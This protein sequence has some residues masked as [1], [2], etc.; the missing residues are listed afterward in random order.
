MSNMV[1]RCPKCATSFRITSGQLKSANGAVR[2]G[3]CLHIFQAQDYFVSSAAPVAIEKYSAVV[4]P[5]VGTLEAARPPR[6]P[7]VKSAPKAHATLQNTNPAQDKNLSSP[8]VEKH[9]Q[10][11]SETSPQQQPRLVAEAQKP[12]VISPSQ[13]GM[14]GIDDDFLI[15][16]DME[17]IDDIGQDTEESTSTRRAPQTVS[18]FERPIHT[19]DEDE[20]QLDPDESWAMHL[21]DE[22]ESEMD[23]QSSRVSDIDQIDLAADNDGESDEEMLL[24]SSQPTDDQQDAPEQTAENPSEAAE[25]PLY[26]VREPLFSLVDESS[27]T[28]EDPAET[29]DSLPEKTSK[30][31]NDSRLRAYD[32]SRAALLMNISPEPLVMTSQHKRR[33]H[34]KPLWFLLGGLMVIA[35][36]VQ[37]G[38]L[39]FSTLSRLEPYR[40]AYAVVCPWLGCK[41]PDLVDRQKIRTYNLVVR[42]HPHAKD[43]LIVDAIILNTA[44]FGQPFP[45]LAL[46]F[47]T[48]DDQL[49]ATRR[50]APNEY[51]D[52]ELAGKRVMPPN[53]PIHLTLELA[54]PGPDAVNYHVYIPE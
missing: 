30:R 28:D 52:G 9:P 32:S 2:C 13:G 34:K 37:I 38:W 6:T 43:V 33:W 3:S 8:P 41:L 53:Q 19:P 22:A 14:I 36:I 26:A 21:L 20:E 5:D 18:L 24:A 40:S 10:A 25:P 7:P 54:D 44:A 42:N 1:T 45:D 47:S 49:V 31:P 29:S 46:A 11:L 48:I 23:H 27:S 4:T 35:L 50:F 12:S 17:P 16:D 39:Q 15:S 51:L